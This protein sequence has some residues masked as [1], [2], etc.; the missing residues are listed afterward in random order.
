M[1]ELEKKLTELLTKHGICADCG[2][3]YSHDL[4]GPFASC[5]CHTSEW[6]DFT[7]YMALQHDLALLTVENLALIKVILQQTLT[8][9]VL[10]EPVTIELKEGDDTASDA[11][12][13]AAERHIK[14]VASKSWSSLEDTKGR[15]AYRALDC[16]LNRCC[17]VSGYVIN[18][19]ETR[20]EIE[21][22]R[23]KCLP[24][25]KVNV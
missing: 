7:P 10:P 22:E 25:N 16:L 4:D 11:M 24:K 19:P 18:D 20:K 14:Q 9:V 8:G 17:P 2:E 12:L 15:A 3:I 6:H 5:G 21:E 13:Y 23:D 1:T